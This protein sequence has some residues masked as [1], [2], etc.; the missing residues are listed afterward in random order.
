MTY[1]TLIDISPTN[2]LNLDEK[3]AFQHFFGKSRAEAQALFGEGDFY[4][5][6]LAWMG[7]VAFEY[8]VLAYIDFLDESDVL[9]LDINDQMIL[10]LQRYEIDSQYVNI[11]KLI[12]KISDLRGKSPDGSRDVVK[13]YDQVIEKI[14]AMGS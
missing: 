12:D 1:P 10:V 11:H 4:V 9:D 7:W 8:Y 6:D 5:D 3:V 2:L 14:R 13:N